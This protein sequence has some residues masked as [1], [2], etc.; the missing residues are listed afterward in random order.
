MTHRKI[1]QPTLAPTAKIRA[2]GVTSVAATILV[3]IA[4]ALGYQLDPALAAA[5]VGAVAWLAGYLTRS[6][7]PPPARARPVGRFE[8]G[9]QDLGG[10][11][12]D[13]DPPPR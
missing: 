3:L 7:A 8:Q 11:I 6:A 5:L 10:V 9:V 2:V 12:D 4:D 1:S 13:P